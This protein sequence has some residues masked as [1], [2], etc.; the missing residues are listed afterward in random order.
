MEAVVQKYV[1]L[2]VIKNIVCSFLFTNCHFNSAQ[3]LSMKI[4]DERSKICRGYCQ[5]ITGR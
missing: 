4:Q 1:D 2:K 3:R 5:N